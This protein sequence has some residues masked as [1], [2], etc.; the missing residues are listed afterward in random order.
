MFRKFGSI[1][2]PPVVIVSIL[3]SFLINI[4]CS[5]DGAY[6]SAKICVISDLH[7][8]DSLL[9]TSGSA[10]EDYLSGSRKLIAES[11][12]ILKSLIQVILS[13]DVEIV[14]VT[15]DLTKDGERK[16]H[17][18]LAEYFR[19]L[20]SAG[21]QVFVVP[22]NHDINNPNAVG[23]SGADTFPVESV[24]AVEFS[25]IYH[26]YGYG[27]ALFRDNGSLSYI[28]RPR[29]G[30]WIMAMDS[31]R[32]EDVPSTGGGFSEST[33]EWIL[34]NL[35]YAMSR[36]ITVFGMMHHGLINHFNTQSL[37]FPDY[38]IDDW[39]GV[40][41]NFAEMEMKIVFTG[42]FHA[43]DIVKGVGEDGGFIFDIET[44]SAITYPCPLRIVE[45]KSDGQLT[46]TS[47]KITS[48]NYDTGGK[49]FQTYAKDFLEY[50]L[51]DTMVESLIDQFKLS[52]SDA[53]IYAPHMA[54]GLIAHYEGDES[55]SPQTR[56]IIEQL[57]EDLDLRKQLLGLGLES[58]WTDLLPGDND[59]LIDLITGEIY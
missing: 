20:E 28:V 38:V 49:S 21:K 43:Q 54:S 23:Y 48:I 6:P 10:F 44:G 58:I 59:I 30:L 12:E 46:V 26:D 35:E 16:S 8:Y 52:Q 2:T 36:N 40:S 7:L 9:G 27:E 50:G 39:K 15:G 51:E 42:H 13:E 17:T 33:L 19:Q 31:C 41:D 29:K 47:R 25:E 14:L 24:S 34:S 57:N 18:M 22:G 3:F 1:F 11:E 45:L 55:P 5:Q 32:Y 37:F 56:A 4:S 53:Q